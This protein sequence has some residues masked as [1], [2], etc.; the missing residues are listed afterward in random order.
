MVHAISIDAKVDS[1]KFTARLLP[2]VLSNGLASN[3]S[4]VYHQHH[5]RSHTKHI[6]TS[7]IY[8]PKPKKPTFALL[9]GQHL[10]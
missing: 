8:T 6:Y 9:H 3:Y 2:L 7:C 1:E 4:H 5:S 10:R